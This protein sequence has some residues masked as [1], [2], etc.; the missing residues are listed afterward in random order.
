MSLSAVIPLS[1]FQQAYVFDPE[2]RNYW[3]VWL[4]CLKNNNNNKRALVE[5]EWPDYHDY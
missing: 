5:I 4:S 2:N 3:Q 1:L